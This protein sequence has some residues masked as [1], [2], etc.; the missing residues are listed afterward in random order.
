MRQ[1][2]EKI[3]RGTLHLPPYKSTSNS[4]EIF[5]VALGNIIIKLLI[6]QK[7][8]YCLTN[9]GRTE[10]MEQAIPQHK[11]ETEKSNTSD[12]TRNKMVLQNIG[13]IL[14]ASTNYE[15]EFKN[16]K[17]VNQNISADHMGQAPGRKETSP[18]KIQTSHQDID[19]LCEKN[20]SGEQK[21][22]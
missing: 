5:G 1:I 3:K 17:L 6:E 9:R 8:S 22:C 14:A 11:A 21:S 20:W 16:T 13:R 15:F 19:Y 2:E 12:Q 10:L 18:A 4:T 7:G